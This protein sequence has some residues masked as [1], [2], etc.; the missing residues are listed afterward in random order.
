M[1]FKEKNY[2]QLNNYLKTIRFKTKNN[3]KNN[4]ELNKRFMH[5]LNE[6]SKCENL[7]Y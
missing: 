7:I 3:R 2:C 1:L 5:C 6:I 4:I